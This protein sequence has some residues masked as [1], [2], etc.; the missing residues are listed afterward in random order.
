MEGGKEGDQVNLYL[1]QQQASASGEKEEAV[2]PSPVV[3]NRPL[4]R[5]PH[6]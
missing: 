1:F 5:E 3:G 2:A 6:V 4:G